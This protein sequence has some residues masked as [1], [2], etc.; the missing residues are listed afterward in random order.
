MTGINSIGVVGAG[1]MGSGIAA[2]ASSTGFTTVL[3]DIDAASVERGLASVAA[4]LDRAV[5]KGGLT[6][7]QRADALA[8]ITGAS[9]LAAVEACDLVIEAAI[10]KEG[11]K[12]E[13]FAALSGIVHPACILA[14]NTSTISITAIASV[15]TDPSRVIGMHFMNPALVMQLVEVVKALQTSEETVHTIIA[16]AGRMGKVPVLVHDSPGFV[17]NRLLMPMINEAVMLLQEGVAE[18][19]AIDTIM[20]LGMNHPMGPLALADLIGLDVCLFVMDVLHRDLGDPKYRPAVLLKQKVAA[21][22]LGRK[23]GSGFYEY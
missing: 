16:A 20:K 3:V 5:A 17:S 10:E 19:E 8:R 13:I 18:A 7:E 1:R 9:S 11:I 21:G 12:K 2:V 15:A 14:T 23:T 22:R 6:K 4:G